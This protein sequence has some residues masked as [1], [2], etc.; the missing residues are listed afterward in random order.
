MV[1]SFCAKLI[2]GLKVFLS[3]AQQLADTGV[4]I[5]VVLVVGKVKPGGWVN[6][7]LVATGRWTLGSQV[8]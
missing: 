3:M 6:A 5:I 4:I 1:R 8:E 2:C 7:V